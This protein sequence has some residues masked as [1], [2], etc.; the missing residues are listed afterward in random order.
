MEGK[1]KDC[2]MG[3][4]SASKREDDYGRRIRMPR[5]RQ[6]K[7]SV[8]RLVLER[9][10]LTLLA[11]AVVSGVVAALWCTVHDA[12]HLIFAQPSDTQQLLSS[13]DVSLT[14]GEPRAERGWA[15]YVGI[16]LEHA[17]TTAIEWTFYTILLPFTALRALYEWSCFS[18]SP[19][20]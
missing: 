17:I 3:K 5:P 9:L 19:T 14:L 16:L 6:S 1:E 18:P 8:C 20:P 11:L 4:Q 7:R 13:A 12:R 15:S 10:L 2:A